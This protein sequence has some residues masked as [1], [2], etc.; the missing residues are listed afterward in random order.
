MSWFSVFTRAGQDTSY[1][2]E[3]TGH[4]LFLEQHLKRL[5]TGNL[6]HLFWTHFWKTVWWTVFLP[7]PGT[8]N[9]LVY[10]LWMLNHWN[11]GIF[12]WFIET[13]REFL[14]A[15]TVGEI[16]AHMVYHIL[17]QGEAG[18]QGTSDEWKSYIALSGMWWSLGRFLWWMLLMQKIFMLLFLKASLEIVFHPAFC[19][20]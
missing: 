7:I 6:D 12:L 20:F 14:V 10:T 9:N 4:H 17:P 18:L 5:V 11:L 3:N 15:Q 8:R 19:C 13:V 1:N 16:Q 2:V